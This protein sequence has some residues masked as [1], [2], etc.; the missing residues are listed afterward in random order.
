MPATTITPAICSSRARTSG[1]FTCQD[2]TGLLL[3]RLQNDLD[4]I[5]LLF[6]EH[7]ESL[8]Y[9]IERQPVRDDEAR[10][11][12]ALLNSF[13]QRLQI[14]LHMRLAG[15]HSQRA[16]HKRSDREFIHQAAVHS[17][18]GNSAAVAARHN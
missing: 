15:A 17:D 5:I 18:D 2:S 6:L 12:L 16:V 1:T 14:A 3:M 13:E 9:L 11:D 7:R 8:R 4:A 10:V